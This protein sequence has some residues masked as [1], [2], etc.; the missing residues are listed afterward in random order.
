MGQ[1]YCFSWWSRWYHVEVE[2]YSVPYFDHIAVFEVP[3]RWTSIKGG[4]HMYF[5]DAWMSNYSLVRIKKL[6]IPVESVV[7][8]CDCMVEWEW[9]SSYSELQNTANHQAK[10]MADHADF[11]SD[12]DIASR[13]ILPTTWPVRVPLHTTYL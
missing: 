12:S 4:I 2:G 11:S 13:E 8:G 10:T 7:A 1:I 9:K 5:V 3:Y 6:N